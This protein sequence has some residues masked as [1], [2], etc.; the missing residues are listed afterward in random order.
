LVRKHQPFYNVQLKDDKSPIYIVITQDEFPRV[1]M[2]RKSGTFGPYTNAQTVRKVLK[3]IRRIYPF[4]Q[5]KVGRKACLYNQMGL[6]SPCPNTIKNSVQKQKYLQNIKNIKKLLSGDLKFVRNDLGKEMQK[7][8][9]K[10]NFEEA[11]KVLTKMQILDYV[12]TPTTVVERYLNNP[13]LAEDLRQQEAQNLARYV[14]GPSLYVGRIECYDVA[15]LAGTNPTASMVTFVDGEPDK[16][17]YRHFKI[18]KARR[19]DD[20][21]ALKEVLERRKKRFEDWGKPDLIIVD[22][23]KGQLSAALEVFG[24][25]LP[26]VGLAK[27]FETLVS[28]QNGKFVSTRLPAGPARNLVV[29][30]RDEAHRFARR[31]HHKQV[32][33]T[34]TQNLPSVVE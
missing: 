12:T 20:Y 30:L 3:L 18:K 21:G 28:F 16:N 14:Q 5:H 32:A 17:R 13:N 15:H 4:S 29:R 11:Q 9:K 10:N 23:G 27:K 1:T 31:L 34:L 25:D 22:G 24:Y 7:Y 8:S 33:K 26:V 2:A 19:G 6:C